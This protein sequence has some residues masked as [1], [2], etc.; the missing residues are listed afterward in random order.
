ME[1]QNLTLYNFGQFYGEQSIDFSTDANKNVTMIH[2]ENGIGKTTLLNAIL[3]CLFETLTPDFERKNELISHEALKNDKN[4]NAYVKLIFNHENEQYESQRKVWA[5][6]ATVHKLFNIDNNN[7]KEIPNPN[8][9][10]NSILPKEMAEYFFFH[11]EGIS[12]IS[13]KNKGEKFRR[14]VRDILGFTFAE[15]AQKDL[16]A[17]K[18]KYTKQ[19]NELYKQNAEL[20]QAADKKERAEESIDNLTEE[21]EKLKEKKQDL[22]TKEEDIIQKLQNTG[23]DQAKK[24]QEQLNKL[25]KEYKDALTSRSSI[26]LERQDMIQ[27]YGW[28]IFGKKVA[29]QDL[30][31]IDSSAFK[32][33]IPAPY[34]ETFVQDLL[35]EGKCICGREIKQNS[36]EW[37]NV[38]RLLEKANTAQI[39]QRLM[40]AR[41]IASNILERSD[42][43]DDE[44]KKI[45]E[46]RS[47]LDKRI[48]SLKHD[49]DDV[50]NKLESIDN[51]KVTRLTEQ[52]R[53]INNDKEAVSRQIGTIERDIQVHKEE[54]QEAGKKL[55]SS[56]AQDTRISNLSKAEDLVE[57][58]TNKIN[59][60]LS[61]FEE[62]ARE[63][64]AI[65]VNDI[66]NKFSRKNYKIK[67]NEDYQFNLVREDGGYV[68]KSKGENLLLNLSFVSAL[69]ALA[70]AREKST[71]DILVQGTVAPFVIDA[72][73]GEL[74]ET[75]KEATAR[76]LPSTSKQLIVLVSSSHWVGKVQETIDTH[77]GKEYLLV[78][79]RSSEK[80]DKPDDIINIR[81]NDYIQSIYASSSDYTQ[82]IE[83]A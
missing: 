17:I 72:P 48:Q 19:S 25:N 69:I 12:S 41:S 5:N 4:S 2:G 62:A 78:S 26:Q 14:A 23:S 45:E 32:G 20:K 55:K 63:Q 79:Y 35:E 77:I 9:F 53:K 8:A 16:K 49:I 43:F 56:P 70:R 40:R 59:S 37:N 64:M 34:Q 28:T 6:G 33:R 31:F 13:D 76:F 71:G 65:L 42:E 83:V 61:E 74:D 47:N 38:S 46:R 30:S 50:N 44:I 60:R 11:G 22:D 52:K 15:E 7:Y 81:G 3:W 36:D 24:Y 39:S 58:L 29:Q 54:A 73:F 68:A 80:G 75:Y 66:L 1:L 27:K 18:K 21:L 57:Q 67:V 51:D 82:I 10:V